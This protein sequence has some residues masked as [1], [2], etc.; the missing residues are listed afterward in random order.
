MELRFTTRR[1]ET[2]YIITNVLMYL[3]IAI[4]LICTVY[5]C[6]KL[7][8]FKAK[9]QCNTENRIQSRNRRS[10]FI[11]VSICVIFILSEVIHV[12]AMV[13][14]STQESAEISSLA[15]G[16]VQYILVSWEIGFALNFVIYFVLSKNLRA[17]VISAFGK[18]CFRA[19]RSSHSSGS[20]VSY[21]QEKVPAVGTA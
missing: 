2:Q 21:Q 15:Q 12:T 13:I 4:M 18:I 3:C 19:R 20:T 17:M 8:V 14:F 10:A 11:V 7:T 1:H 5:I 6:L 9:I 16:V